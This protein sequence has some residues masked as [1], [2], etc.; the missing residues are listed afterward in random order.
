M[1]SE[2]LIESAHTGKLLPGKFDFVPTTVSQEKES[3]SPGATPAE[4]APDPGGEVAPT[5]PP[6]RPTGRLAQLTKGK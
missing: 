1:G 5:P 2:Q 3:Q 6:V 4:P